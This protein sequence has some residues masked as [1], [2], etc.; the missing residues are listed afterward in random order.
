MRAACQWRSGRQAAG[1]AAILLLWRMVGMPSARHEAPW[2]AVFARPF[3]S[4]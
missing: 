2:A 1:I 4:D 3:T